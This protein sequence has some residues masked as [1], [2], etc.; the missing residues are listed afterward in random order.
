MAWRAVVLGLAALAL[1][2][3]GA[4]L[5]AAA[6]A[7]AVGVWA[8]GGCG[9]LALAIAFAAAG[10]ASPRRAR[11]RWT[12]SGWRL[13]AEP[14]ADGSIVLAIDLGAW[15]LL[16]FAPEGARWPWRSA[17]LPVAAGGIAPA[18]WHTL[19]CAVHAAPAPAPGGRPAVDA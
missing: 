1:T 10:V 8:I 13:G 11:L 15:M 5:V 14:G 18:D 12:G 6:D 16:R 4:W 3:F 19:R 17:W 2:S 7:S 9:A